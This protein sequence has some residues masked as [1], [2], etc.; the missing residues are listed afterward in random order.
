MIAEQIANMPHGGDRKSE[1]IKLRD[2]GLISQAEA[3]RQLGTTP[4]KGRA[5][6]WL[7]SLSLRALAIAATL[8]S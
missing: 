3:A 2:L 6:I 5:H 4:L 8:Q 1:E 7:G